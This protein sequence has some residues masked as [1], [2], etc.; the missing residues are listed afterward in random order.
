MK[1]LISN[2]LKKIFNNVIVNKKIN[3]SNYFLYYEKSQHLIFAF[4]K[5]I[6]YESNI[7]EKIKKHIDKGDLVFDIGG[8]IGQ[9]ALV[10]SS[11]V[12][13]NGKVISVEPDYKNFSFLQFNVTINQIKNIELLKTG[14]DK[15]SNSLIF[16]RDTVTGGRKGSFNKDYVNESYSG[17]NETVTTTTID[18][19]ID[20]Y[21]VPSFIKIDVEGFE[22][23]VING[24]TKKL[25]NTTFLIEV[26]KE[27]KQEIFDYFKTR[28]YVCYHLD[29]TE[30]VLIND[31][32][33]IP[34]FANLL[35][36]IN[37]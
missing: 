7:Q 29:P 22:S 32:H 28:L 26:R 1:Q 31:A 17:F 10:L 15:T 35:F 37:H 34:D 11:L 9:Y 12:G 27:T 6:N 8:N 4:K 5:L 3:N 18:N 30:S 2:I 36:L 13:E 19:L 16:F 33:Q 24:L 14:L 21:G 20:V 23:N 25:P